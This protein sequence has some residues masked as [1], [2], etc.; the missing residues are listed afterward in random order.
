MAGISVG[1]MRG[2]NYP[3]IVLVLI[4]LLQGLLPVQGEHCRIPCGSAFSRVCFYRVP[5]L[6]CSF[7]S[8]FSSESHTQS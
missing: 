3:Y 4:A 2:E 7:D 5:P 1:E 8:A 6:V